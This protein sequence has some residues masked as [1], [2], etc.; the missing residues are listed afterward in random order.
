MSFPANLRVSVSA[1]WLPFWAAVLEVAAFAA[2]SA[3]LA[4]PR[5]TALRGGD[6]SG[7]VCP[8]FSR[9]ARDHNASGGGVGDMESA[10]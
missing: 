9:Y 3:R 5:S 6:C 10:A 1:T 4:A 7:I 8:Q 2:A